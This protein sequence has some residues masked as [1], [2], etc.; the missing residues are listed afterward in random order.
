[1]DTRD[2]FLYLHHSNHFTGKAAW[3]LA[4]PMV[5]HYRTALPEHNSVAWLLWHIARGEDW[6][7]QTIL[8]GREQLLTRDGWDSRMRVAEPSFGGGMERSQMIALS[9][10]IDLDAMRGYYTAVADATQA[11]M[12]TFDFATIDVL[13]DVQP[14]LALVPEAQGPSPFLRQAFTRWTTPLLWLEVF[15]LVDVSFH[16]ADAD[17]VLA[18]LVPDRE[19][20]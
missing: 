9:E 5:A 14:R 8:Q 7:V 19:T 3:T 2:F 15:T 6:A 16:I 4:E 13:F 20:D 18:L 10:Q 11:Y 17:H 12:R 1:L